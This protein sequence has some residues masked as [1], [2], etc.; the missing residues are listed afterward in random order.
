MAVV[1][2]LLAR[3]A[4]VDALTLVLA[5]ASVVCLSGFRVNS[6]WLVL[7][8]AVIGLAANA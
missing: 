6:S 1:A 3:A 7:G 8:A 4:V 2:V 5:L